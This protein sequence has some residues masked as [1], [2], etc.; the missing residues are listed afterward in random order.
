L[1]DARGPDAP[2]P[3]P[4]LFVLGLTAGWALDRAFPLPLTGP[5]GRLAAE[6]AGGLLVALGLAVSAWG[7]A[8]FRA[9]RTAVSPN[10][11]AST[12]VTHGPFRLSRNPMYLGLTVMCVGVA[13]LRNS[14]WTVLLLPLV[15]ALLHWTV[16]VREERHLAA[17]FGAAYETYRRRVRRWL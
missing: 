10:R 3:P 8:T 17:T 9:A 7:F 5:D 12:L 1:A 2:Y 14:S 4:V 13:L 15:I 6:L 11:P 16:I